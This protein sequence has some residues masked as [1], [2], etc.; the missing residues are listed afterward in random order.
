MVGVLYKKFY[1]SRHKILASVPNKA[2]CAK[3]QKGIEDIL[4]IIYRIRSCP[5]T[6]HRILEKIANTDI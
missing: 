2:I 4:V 1:D 3:V 6:W 5:E